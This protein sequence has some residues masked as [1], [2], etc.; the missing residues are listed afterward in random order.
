MARESVLPP[1]GAPRPPSAADHSATKKEPFSSAVGLS[2]D[3]TTSPSTPSRRAGF[4]VISARLSLKPDFLLLFV[5]FVVTTWS[6]DRVKSSLITPLCITKDFAFS[7]LVWIT[8]L[9]Q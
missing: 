8:L 3:N 1:G 6:L 5:F 4:D 9:S 2:A 7:S